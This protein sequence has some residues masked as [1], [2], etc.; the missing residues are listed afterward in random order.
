MPSKL[1]AFTVLLLSNS[2]L[3][4]SYQSF[5]AL[6]YSQN[7]ITVNVPWINHSS[8]YKADHTALFSQY[9]FDAQQTLGPLNEFNYINTSS[10]IY[11][12]LSNSNTDSFT[13]HSDGEE[14]TWGGSSNTID[15]GGQWISHNFIV[16]ASYSYLDYDTSYNTLS[17]A[18]N[19][20]YYSAELGYLISDNF[21]INAYYNDGGDG[22][23]FF[24]YSASYALQLAGTDYVGV[25]YN[26]DEDFDIH[27]LSARYFFGIAAQ[28]YVVIGGDY[29]LDTRDSYSSI[30]SR[31]SRDNFIVG[32]KWSINASYYYNDKTS[33]SVEYSDDELSEDDYAYGVSASYYINSNYSLQT[34][35][36]SVINDDDYKDTDSYYVA[37]T[38]QF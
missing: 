11:A 14:M 15:L 28:S 10:N 34:G 25:S 27:Q 7:N 17:Y 20:S 22:D 36:N 32:D 1:A 6:A 24:A 33:I 18:D 35:Y 38:A 12:G 3:A 9:Y 26:V 30:N 13:S 8:K 5:S 29:T 23:D 37:F 4:E 21:V 19:D 2:V 16:G 31:A